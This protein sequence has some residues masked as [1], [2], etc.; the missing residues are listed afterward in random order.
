M[1]KKPY[2]GSVKIIVILTLAM[3]YGQLTLHGQPWSRRITNFNGNNCELFP[4]LDKGLLFTILRIDR[5]SSYLVKTN[6]NGDELWSLRVGSGKVYNIINDLKVL[7]DGSTLLCGSTDEY[8]STDGDPF[9]MKLNSCG[10]ILWTKIFHGY[11][12]NFGSFVHVLSDESIILTCYH[13]NK[14]MR[15]STTILKL[16]P[17]CE[18]IWQFTTKNR[19]TK[20][21]L[22]DEAKGK[23]LLTGA[24]DRPHKDD[25]NVFVLRAQV[26]EVNFNGQ[27]N[28]YKPYRASE[29]YICDFYSSQPTKD[30][31]WLTLGGDRNPGPKGEP[32]PLL[33]KY[34]ESGQQEWARLLEYD[35][36]NGQGA[37]VF[38]NT[39]GD[40]FFAMYDMVKV[41][42]WDDMWVKTVT[43]DAK[44]NILNEAEH[45]K[46]TYFLGYSAIQTQGG[47]FLLSGDRGRYVK[48]PYAMKLNPDHS[49]A[50]FDTVNTY[51]YDSLCP[52]PITPGT[53]TFDNAEL[54]FVNFDSITVDN[55]FSTLPPEPVEAQ[56]YVFPNP[57]KNKLHIFSDK[58]QPIGCHYYI[59]DMTGKILISERL[60]G[61]TIDVSGLPCGVFLVKVMSHKET[62]TEKFIK[63]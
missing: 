4:S 27:Q 26:T 12:R 38:L 45:G 16:A 25:S 29:H 56:V 36:V 54:I 60:T 46:S 53:L 21:V 8:D 47:G 59:M 62:L 17:N 9:L 41:P 18:I 33:V 6:V 13:S 57:A 51:T 23:I 32:I 24:T 28:F 58:V 14:T 55:T 40:T 34:S 35:S 61:N 63:R 50:G 39:G 7:G 10:E 49:L 1:D 20:H 3:L 30:G 19:N 48:E 37:Q 2:F 11:G 43:M 31:G 44:G 22:I 15:Q 42:L 5:K 52:H